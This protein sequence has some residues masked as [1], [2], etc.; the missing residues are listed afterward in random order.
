MTLVP[1]LL[2]AAAVWGL[3]RVDRFLGE[4][5]R[6]QIELQSPDELW[7]DVYEAAQRSQMN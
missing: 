1:S 3:Y 7:S 2:L 5:E 6:R 4:A